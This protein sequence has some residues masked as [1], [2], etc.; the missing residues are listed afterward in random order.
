[1]WNNIEKDSKKLPAPI[2]PVAGSVPA[3]ADFVKN[4][5][6]E[7]KLFWHSKD[8]TYLGICTKTD[9][10]ATIIFS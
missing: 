4:D 1:M 2:D 7:I 10:F 3:G 6:I 8:Y 9:V 5:F